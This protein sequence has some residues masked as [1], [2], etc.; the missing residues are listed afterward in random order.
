M[1]CQSL[2]QLSYSDSWMGG[3]L[4]QDR[5]QWRFYCG[6][7][8]RL[9]VSIKCGKF[10]NQVSANVGI[11]RSALLCKVGID[12]APGAITRCGLAACNGFVL[13]TTKPLL[14]D[15]TVFIVGIYRLHSAVTA[16]SLPHNTSSLHTT[17]HLSHKVSC[18]CRLALSIA[19]RI[20]TTETKGNVQT[21][22]WVTD[23]DPCMHI[24]TFV[25]IRN[26]DMQL[27]EGN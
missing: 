24:V 14:H 27:W 25:T 22:A 9:P 16:A 18:M 2:Y 12:I 15:V 3:C 13:R 17:V 8:G 7:G 4:A 10:V 5:D 23:F 1:S 20:L 26:I 6:H 19:S 21:V 11:W